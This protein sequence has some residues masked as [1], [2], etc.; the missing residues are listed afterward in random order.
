E[1]W[2][3]VMTRSARPSPERSGTG[4]T[5]GPRSPSRHSP[6]QA[7]MSA[8]VFPDHTV[9][10]PFWSTFCWSL[11]RAPAATSAWPS[12]STSRGSPK[13]KPSSPCGTVPAKRRATHQ[14]VP[15]AEQNVAARAGDG[16][17]KPG[18]ERQEKRKAAVEVEGRR[19]RHG[20]EIGRA[21]CRER[22]EIVGVCE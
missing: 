5:Q 16:N 15:G 14:P 8:P 19:R 1:A 6:S 13:R 4:K 10:L 7:R 17:A 22:G 18:I 11:K 9:A 3:A 20:R 12:P 21:S 2:G